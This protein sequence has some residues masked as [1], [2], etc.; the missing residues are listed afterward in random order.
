MVDQAFQSALVRRTRSL[1]CQQRTQRTCRQIM[2]LKTIRKEPARD[3]QGTFGARSSASDCPWAYR[4]FKPPFSPCTTVSPVKEAIPFARCFVK[5]P[6]SRGFIGRCAGPSRPISTRS[7][8]HTKAQAARDRRPRGRTV[9]A[10]SIRLPGSG[11]G[12]A[13]VGCGAPCTR[14][15]TPAACAPKEVPLG[16]TRTPPASHVR[17][18]HS[19][20]AEIRSP[21]MAARNERPRTGSES[22]ATPPESTGNTVWA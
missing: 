3:V 1:D 4:K 5:I 15:R 9:L 16:D 8:R 14:G 17:S 22:T 12:R 18:Q 21:G 19:A 6:L 7:D 20:R 2:G 11:S 13:G 10:L